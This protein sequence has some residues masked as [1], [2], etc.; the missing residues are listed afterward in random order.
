MPARAPGPAS[1]EE[2]SGE[3]A[4]GEEASGEEVSRNQSLRV[5]APWFEIY[6]LIEKFS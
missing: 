2:A 1:G 4:S 6:T 5:K 3:E